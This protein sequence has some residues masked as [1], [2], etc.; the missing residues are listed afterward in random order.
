V[1]S[2]KLLLPIFGLLLSTCLYG[3]GKNDSAVSAEVQTTDIGDQFVQ[4]VEANQ[5]DIALSFLTEE[6]R[7]KINSSLFSNANGDLKSVIEAFRQAGISTRKQQ[8][9]S[10]QRAKELPIEVKNLAGRKGVVKVV[11]INKEGEW[12]IAN[13]VNGK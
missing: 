6:A 7:S 9:I 10:Y 3:C 4:A 5:P 2:N 1:N 8:G 11:L 12:R 13:I